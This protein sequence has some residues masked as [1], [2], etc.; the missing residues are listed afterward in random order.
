MQRVA[1]RP[2]FYVSNWTT[3][4]ADVS[5]FERF[6]GP[7]PLDHL[8]SLAV[9]EQFY[10]V[11][12]LVLLFMLEV[13]SASTNRQLIRWTLVLGGGLVRSA[14]VAGC[15]WLRQHPRLRRHRHPSR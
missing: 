5:Y 9:E 13:A 1:C 6:G 11:W 15:P 10:L 8:W 14:G 3:I 12:P 2:R 7:G 4:A